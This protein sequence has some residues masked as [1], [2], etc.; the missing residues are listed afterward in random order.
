MSTTHISNVV[1][2]FIYIQLQTYTYTF[3]TYI[4]IYTQ[5]SADSGRRN[6]E[7]VVKIHVEGGRTEKG[8]GGGED[9]K[10]RKQFHVQ[11]RLGS[12]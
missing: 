9:E 12:V 4:Y 1:I 5:S 11:V 8:K 6:L 3:C 7:E 10:G 2:S